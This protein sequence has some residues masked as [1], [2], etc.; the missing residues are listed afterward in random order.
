MTA[1]DASSAASEVGAG[2]MVSHIRHKLAASAYALVLP[3]IDIY[4]HVERMRNALSAKNNTS[5]QFT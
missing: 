2:H 3:H 1:A 5:R 4:R